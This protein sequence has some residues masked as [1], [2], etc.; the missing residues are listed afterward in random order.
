M[1]STPTDTGDND[2][3]DGLR[4]PLS[5][6]KFCK[7]TVRPYIVF[8]VLLTVYVFAGGYMFHV[9]EKPQWNK[10]MQDFVALK[11]TFIEE[12]RNS[13]RLSDDNWTIFMNERM[14]SLGRD[15]E[16]IYEQSVKVRLGYNWDFWSS[17]FFCTTVLTTVGYGTVVPATTLGKILCS[18]YAIFGIPIFLVFLAK[19][20]TVIAQCLRN[21]YKTIIIKRRKRR[22]TKLS[23]ELIIVT[24]IR[25][26]VN[27]DEIHKY[28]AKGHGSLPE[29]S[30]LVGDTRDLSEAAEVAERQLQITSDNESHTPEVEG[31]NQKTFNLETRVVDLDRCIEDDELRVPIYVI[32]LI[33]IFYICASAVLFWKIEGWTYID[34][35]Y[36]CTITYTTVGFGDISPSYDKRYG[37]S[38]Q[39][40]YTTF[41]FT[42]L[43]LTSTCI[44]LAK[45]RLKGVYHFVFDEDES[46]Q[47]KP[48]SREFEP[49]EAQVD[50]E[51]ELTRSVS[52]P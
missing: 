23:A 50:H 28:G 6:E 47:R 40:L 16:T 20:S 25:E 45:I 10:N 44:N 24:D 35:V 34:S 39:I 48:A 29:K 51:E 42:G 22:S 8:Y 33:V 19:A 7:R 4:Q 37:L 52:L 38:K 32:F 14:D 41:V 31:G 26:N 3:A 21:I 17:I 11:E 13:C 46:I 15:I 27:D 12:L 5:C 9:V 30:E 43:I 18:I 1:V 49:V 36:F 2:P